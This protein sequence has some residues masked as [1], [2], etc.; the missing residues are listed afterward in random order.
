[1]ARQQ[2]EGRPVQIRPGFFGAGPAL[3]RVRRLLG[4]A[5][6]VPGVHAGLALAQPRRV[7]NGSAEIVD[8]LTRKWT[9]EPD[10]RLAVTARTT[11]P[12]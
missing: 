2:C 9:R 4:P 11:M 6:S 7:V 8:F 10:Y 1:M 5:A 12:A 3:A